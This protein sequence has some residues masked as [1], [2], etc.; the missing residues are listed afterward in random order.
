MERKL[1][2]TSFS[3]FWENARKIIADNALLDDI[4]GRWS[5]DREF[6]LDGDSGKR[7]KITYEDVGLL[8]NLPYRDH[9]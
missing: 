8:F 2:T 4:Y 6:K 5:G 1:L 3:Y 9:R 7:L